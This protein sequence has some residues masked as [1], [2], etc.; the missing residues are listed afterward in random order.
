MCER[1]RICETTASCCARFV[2]VVFRHR[3]SG[4]ACFEYHEATLAGRRLL[5]SAATYPATVRHLRT[6]GRE[7]MK[8]PSVRVTIVATCQLL[9]EPSRRAAAA[10]RALNGATRSE[11]AVSWADH[12]GV[13]QL[14]RKALTARRF[15][16]VA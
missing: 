1:A 8:P 11:D 14:G 4:P 6:A 15:T 3:F 5:L 7:T 9:G 16:P 10:N 12:E 2:F 13:I